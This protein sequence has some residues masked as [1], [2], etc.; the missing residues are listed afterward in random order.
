MMTEAR[1][2][3]TK[4]IIILMSAVDYL[5]FLSSMQSSLGFTS[6]KRL[7]SICKVTVQYLLQTIDPCIQFAFIRPVLWQLVTYYYSSLKKGSIVKYRYFQKG[8]AKN[9]Y[10]NCEHNF[11]LPPP[12]GGNL[13]CPVDYLLQVIPAASMFAPPILL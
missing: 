3:A 7:Y 6:F 9:S 10:E 1:R 5:H 11:V 4:S 13:K 8:N 2:M 12:S